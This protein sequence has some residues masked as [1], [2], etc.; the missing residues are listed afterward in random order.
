M[1]ALGPD[2]ASPIDTLDSEQV[3][4]HNLDKYLRELRRIAQLL[5]LKDEVMAKVRMS[6]YV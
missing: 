2:D 1:P 4:P 6:Q 5:K 3:P